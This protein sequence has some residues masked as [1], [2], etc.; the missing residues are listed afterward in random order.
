MALAKNSAKL[1]SFDV[2]VVGAGIIGLT[3]AYE[4]SLR[5]PETRV[6]VVSPLQLDGIASNAAGAMLSAHG[7]T[8][9]S[10]FATEA[11]R[12]KSRLRLEAA[13]LW[14]EWCAKLSEHCPRVALQPRSGTVVIANAISGPCDERNFQ[15]ICDAA[16]GDGAR[17]EAISA[18]EVQG[19]NPQTQ[20]RPLRAIYLPGE[21]YID[22]AQVLGALSTFLSAQPNIALID[23]S[24]LGVKANAAD[25]IHTLETKVGS[26]RSHVIVL[27]AGAS[28]AS[29][30]ECLGH[31]AG[32]I[33]KLFCGTGTAFVCDTPAGGP[34]INVA[35]RTPNRA[36]ACGLH[37]LPFMRDGLY[38]GATN[39]VQVDPIV[40]PVLGD[41]GFLIECATHQVD[42]RLYTSAVRNTLT[43]NRPVTA[44][45]FPLLGETSIRGIWIAT[46]TYRDGF[47]MAPLLAC[48]L[49]DALDRG[50]AVLAGAEIFRPERPPLPVV[51]D[52]ATAIAEGVENYVSAAFERNAHLPTAGS[53]ESEFRMVLEQR[54]SRIY[55]QLASPFLLPPDL[56]WDAER[57]A[58]G[59]AMADYYRSADLAWR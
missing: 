54:V 49:V 21:Q 47:L 31:G 19:L 59:P 32:R 26:I 36:F 51:R 25:G 5:S 8:T 55:A 29:L 53:W 50:D 46:G 13:R 42:R 33:P 17:L 7:E 38:V 18:E 1:E 23:A 56:L 11:A 4:I 44:D 20:C 6:A 48:K 58:L 27:A 10:S 30:I 57:G 15:A 12:L 9:T 3:I 52:M 16:K 45:T 28:T 40:S 37:V 14:P 24:C 2:A 43:G 22:A 41:L 39:N 34:S 35:I